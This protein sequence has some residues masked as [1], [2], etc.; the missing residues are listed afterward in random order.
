MSS[1]PLAVQHIHAT[2]LAVLLVPL[3]VWAMHHERGITGATKEGQIQFG[4]KM[5]ISEGAFQRVS[6]FASA[7]Q[8]V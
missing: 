6:R 2:W 8:L 1:P 3:S 4:I 5:G 7:S